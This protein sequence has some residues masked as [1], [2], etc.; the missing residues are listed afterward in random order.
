MARKTYALILGLL[1]LWVEAKASQK[2]ISVEEALRGYLAVRRWEEELGLSDLALAHRAAVRWLREANLP[3]FSVLSK[4]LPPPETLYQQAYALLHKLLK[5]GYLPAGRTLFFHLYLLDREKALRLLPKLCELDRNNLYGFCYLKKPSPPEP[6][7]LK[8][9][10]QALLTVGKAIELSFFPG[11]LSKARK[12]FLLAYH[13]GLEEGASAMARSYV[14]EAKKKKFVCTLP[15]SPNYQ[16]FLV[17]KKKSWEN[18]LKEAI[19]WY[20]ATT[21]TYEKFYRIVRLTALLKQSPLS[22]REK[23]FF[24]SKG[25]TLAWRDLVPPG[26]RGISPETKIFSLTRKALDREKTGT[27]SPEKVKDLLIK[28]CYEGERS[29]EVVLADFLSDPTYRFEVYRYHALR[30]NAAAISRLV[31][32]LLEKGHVEEAREWLELGKRLV[33]HTGNLYLLESKVL[34]KQGKQ[35]EAI[36]LLEDLSQKGNCRALEGLFRLFPERALKLHIPED[37]HLSPKLVGRAYLKSGD[38]KKALFY[39]LRVPKERRTAKLER[40]IG[41]IYL[42][43]GNTEEAKRWLLRA[44]KKGEPLNRSEKIFLAEELFRMGIKDGAVYLG[45][46]L[47]S[48]GKRAFCC[49]LLAAKKREPGAGFFLAKFLWNYPELQPELKKILKSSGCECFPAP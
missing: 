17:N 4:A 29:A 47:K 27:C 37:C 42:Q 2:E 20:R 8:A 40:M 7:E 15:E 43:L 1:L 22:A 6:E 24:A 41:E 33:V 19:R 31:T 14:R 45:L 3:E 32:W 39:F 9:H 21:R 35:E 38:L 46:A 48:E 28:A 44:A 26:K 25:V 30:G 34:L 13:M 49:A 5:A 12:Y 11:G 10:P 16:E 18:L 23:L 36:R